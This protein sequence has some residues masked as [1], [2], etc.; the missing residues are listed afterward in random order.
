VEVAGRLATI[1]DYEMLERD[2]PDAMRS[3]NLELARRE[4]A[5]FYAYACISN[6]DCRISNVAQ[7]GVF[8]IGRK[9]QVKALKAFL[10]RLIMAVF[11]AFTLLAPMLIMTLHPTK[12]TVLLTTTLFVLVVAGIL[13]AVM[14]TAEDKDIIAATA[15]YAAV[16]VVFVG[17]ASTSGKLSDG[18]IGGI[19]A[20]AVGAL[21]LL[22][23]VFSIPVAY[24]VAMWA[25]RRR[26]KSYMDVEL[27]IDAL[28]FKNQG[29]S[30]V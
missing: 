4:L 18:L 26:L 2:Q 9:E 5:R 20:G 24:A 13:A 28:S 30:P 22:L 25:K 15:A 12:L 17:S 21:L 3:R 6:E 19:V 11:G 23:A 10:S 7:R 8:F 16:L 1:E 14:K 27:S 29:R